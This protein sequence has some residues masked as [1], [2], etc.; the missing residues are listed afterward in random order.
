MEPQSET[1]I[2]DKLDG[3]SFTLDRLRSNGACVEYD[4]SRDL[5]GYKHGH[6]MLRDGSQGR[7]TEYVPGELTFTK[8][9]HRH[10]LQFSRP[11]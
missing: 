2:A 11:R 8:N 5:N 1:T 9:E 10:E 7:F 3:K 4:A 6:V